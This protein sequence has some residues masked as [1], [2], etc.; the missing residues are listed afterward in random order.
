MIASMTET[1]QENPARLLEDFVP[2]ERSAAEL[3]AI[4]Y[5]AAAG[6]QSAA[7]DDFPA[8]LEY[9]ADFLLSTSVDLENGRIFRPDI[10]DA[11]I[12]SMTYYRV[13]WLHLISPGHAAEPGADE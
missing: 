7:A 11:V 4:L 13:K 9:D 10:R 6:R 3:A 5:R 2:G 8:G 1:Q 12:A